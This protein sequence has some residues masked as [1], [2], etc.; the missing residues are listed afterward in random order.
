[1]KR[2][3][4]A[5]A[6]LALPGVAHAYT[7]GPVVRPQLYSSN[8][9][10]EI[11]PTVG[12]VSNDPY[13]RIIIPGAMVDI[14]FGERSA[15][16]IHGGYGLYSGKQLLSQVNQK[17]G[18]DPDVVSRPKFF[19]TGNYMWTPIYGKINAFGE[20]V[21]H[22]DLFVLAG[23]G[24]TSD[25]IEITNAAGVSTFTTKVFPA[26]DFSLGQ[27]FYLSRRIALRVELRPYIFWE[28]INNKWDPNG[29][30]QIDTGLSFLF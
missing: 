6:F 8:D 13:N 27:R 25:E 23:A 28:Q 19:L 2:I 11:S 14:H 9:K 16:D 18:H 24:V 5:L 17:I 1:M 10:F 4:L 20:V 12:Y 30:V 26:T 3:V 7:D 15:I 29:D 21:L 22:Y